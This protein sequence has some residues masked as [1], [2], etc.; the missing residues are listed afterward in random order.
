MS[1][2]SSKTGRGGRRGAARFLATVSVLEG[3]ESGKPVEVRYKTRNLS[4]AGLLLVC[5]KR[6]PIGSEKLLIVDHQGERLRLR[7]RVTHIQGDGIGFVF[8]QPG[9]AF[10]NQLRAALAELGPI[11][12]PGSEERREDGRVRTDIKIAWAI[13]DEER[14]DRLRNLAAAGAFVVSK[15]SLELDTKLNLYLPAYTY[16]GSSSLPSEVRGCGAVV[17]RV[18]EEGFALRFLHPSAEFKMAVRD[19]LIRGENKAPTPSSES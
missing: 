5:D 9:E 14:Q 16:S 19:L 12:V 15:T 4:L 17:V 1:K 3:V 13:G 2:E 6:W 8:C 7:G 10:L 18:E 11:A